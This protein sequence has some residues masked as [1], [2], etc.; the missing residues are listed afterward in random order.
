MKGASG[1]LSLIA[2]GGV[3]GVV[4]RYVPDEDLAA[5]DE[6]QVSTRGAA[7][8]IRL[9]P[10]HH[11]AIGSVE[12]TL[13]AVSL[14]RGGRFTVYEYR[15]KKAVKSSFEREQWLEGIRAALGKRVEV[16]GLVEYNV[17]GEPLAIKI[18]RLRILGEGRLPTTRELG[19]SDPDFTGDMSTDEFI[20]T[21]RGG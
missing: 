6:A 19:G 7:N 1:L 5:A 18:D 13:E 20:R 16:G 15:T 21:I 10:V 8:I 9:L 12:G 17:R 14:H 11:K 4:V 3:T 2:K